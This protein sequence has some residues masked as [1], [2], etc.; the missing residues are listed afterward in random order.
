MNTVQIQLQRQQILFQLQLS[1]LILIR[2]RHTIHQTV[3][4]MKFVMSWTDALTWHS[5]QSTSLHLSTLHILNTIYFT[6]LHFT[7]LPFIP[8]HC[9]SVPFTPSPQFTSLHPNFTSHHFPSLNFKFSPQFTSLHLDF[10]SLHLTSLHFWI[11][12]PTPSLRLITFLT[13]FLKLFDLEERVPTASAGRRFQCLTLLFTEKYFSVSCHSTSGWS[14]SFVPLPPKVV[15]LTISALAFSSFSLLMFQV[16]KLQVRLTLH[17]IDR[18]AAKMSGN[19]T[20]ILGGAPSTKL[21]RTRPRPRPA[22]WSAHTHEPHRS[23]T[24]RSRYRGS[25]QTGQT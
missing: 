16:D 14:N 17:Q 25:F 18:E 7:S 20:A 21:F 5:L 24:S 10:T 2:S 22:G 19:A 23:L 8:L 13:L 15:S 6:S 12:T 9:T 1:K 3:T 4:V 11:I